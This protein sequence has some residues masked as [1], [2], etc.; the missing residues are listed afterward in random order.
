[1]RHFRHQPLLIWTISLTLL[2]GLLIIGV[3]SADDVTVPQAAVP[4]MQTGASGAEELLQRLPVVHSTIE[5]G[6]Y[7]E[8][9]AEYA[10]FARAEAAEHREDNTVAWNAVLAAVS[11]AEE[12][13]PQDRP[14]LLGVL[15]ELNSAVFSLV[16]SYR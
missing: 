14:A 1:M 15:A 10:A 4:L 12:S 5:A 7:S 16:R 13:D 6:T 2:L 11:S 9:I 3:R 8:W